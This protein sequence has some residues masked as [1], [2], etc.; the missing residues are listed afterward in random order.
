VLI[1]RTPPHL[2]RR[3]PAAAN[4]QG[5]CG[6]GQRGAQL[7]RGNAVG[8]GQTPPRPAQK[9]LAPGFRAEPLQTYLPQRPRVHGFSAAAAALREQCQRLGR[10]QFALL[11]DGLDI[12]VA[13]EQHVA[14]VARSRLLRYRNGA[15][16]TAAHKGAQHGLH[17][18]G[19]DDL[20][21]YNTEHDSVKPDPPQRLEAGAR[22]IPG[23]ARLTLPREEHALKLLADGIYHLLPVAADDN[24]NRIY[25]DRPVRGDTAIDDGYPHHRETDLGQP[26]RA[27]AGTSSGGHYDTCHRLV[28]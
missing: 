27:H 11:D 21:A 4:A 19:P 22:G 5:A 28:G 14:Q 15:V 20:I 3:D 23:A 17:G 25:A 7:R 1:R 16:G 8:A 13:I 9:P 10:T 2:G 24:H 26:P 18:L 12:A 6:R